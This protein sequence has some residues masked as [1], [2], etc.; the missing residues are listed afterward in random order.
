MATDDVMLVGVV[1]GLVSFN[2]KFYF[3]EELVAEAQ[4]MQRKALNAKLDGRHTDAVAL[5]RKLIP[6]LDKLDELAAFNVPKGLQ[7]QI[8]RRTIEQL[9]ERAG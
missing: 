2:G 9:E 6:Y 4:A 7:T 3:L 5:Y 8:A 1:P